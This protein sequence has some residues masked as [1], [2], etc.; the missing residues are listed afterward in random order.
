V[1]WDRKGGGNLCY[2]PSKKENRCMPTSALE[3]RN[4]SVAGFL[5][6]RPGFDPGYGQVGFVV[7]KV[8]LGRVF[9]KYFGFP[10]QSSFHQILHRHN[11][12]G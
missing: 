5:P 3:D 6:Q 9:S 8:G 10:C 12:L 4:R 7:D 1:N 2:K 11:H